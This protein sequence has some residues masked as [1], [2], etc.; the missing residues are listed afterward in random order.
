MVELESLYTLESRGKGMQGTKEVTW[1]YVVRQSGKHSAMLTT[2]ALVISVPQML[3]RKAMDLRF[4]FEILVI[5]CS[6]F[7]PL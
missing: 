5:S 3:N 4:Y 7:R 2:K 1:I 6:H